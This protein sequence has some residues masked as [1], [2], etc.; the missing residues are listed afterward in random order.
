MIPIKTKEEIEIMQRGG[1]ILAGV[2]TEVIKNAQP[3]VKTKELDQLAEQLII[4]NKAKPGFK[5]VKGYHWASCININDGLVHGIPGD[6]KIK[7]GDVVTIDLG[8]YYQGFHTDM[9][10]TLLVQNQ[11]S[12]PPAGRAGIKNQK[13]IERFL[14]VGKLALKN[15]TAM[16]QPRNY[17]G[18]ISKAIQE[19]IEAAG[20]NCS[21]RFTGHG[22]GKELHEEPKILCFLEGEIETTS[23]LKEGV[24]LAIE[25]IYTE[26]SSEIK[27]AKNGWTVKTID[28]KLGGLFENTVAVTKAGPSVLTMI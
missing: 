13:S 1:R 18:H 19:T 25:I 11:K 14:R 16:A 7:T 22:V 26:G 9:A 4:K 2:M 23:Q 12:N 17:I 10:R 24:I 15:A 6:Y 21:R 27:I 28:A 20:Y 5:M 8:A 3:G